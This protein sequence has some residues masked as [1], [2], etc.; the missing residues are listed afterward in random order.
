[1]VFLRGVYLWM[2]V[3]LT[4]LQSR[5]QSI[6]FNHLTIEN[7]LSHNSV[8]S[9]T[10]D[11]RGF[12]WYGTR[13]GLNRYDGARFRIYRMNLADTTTIPDN[14]IQYLFCD[15]KGTL[16]IGTTRGL[17]KYQPEKDAFERITLFPNM[18]PNVT[19]IYEDTKGRIW[20]ATNNGLVLDTGGTRKVFSTEH[21]L[22]GKLIRC[23]YE[24]KKGNIWVGT[25]T[26]L[27]RLRE[28]N[29]RFSFETFR[30]EDAGLPMNYITAV[31]EDRQGRIWIGTQSGGICLYNP[32]RHTFTPLL[33][34][35]PVSNYVRRILADKAGKMWI[36]TQEGLSI[37]DPVSLTGSNY[38]HNP[39]NKKSLSQNSIH[40]LYE[41][42]NGSIWIG[43]YF[44]GVNMIHSYGTAFMTWQ[45]NP[46]QTGLSNNVVS[47][48]WEDGHRNLWIGTE[49]GGLNYLNR[50][51]GKYTYYRH[52]PGNVGSIG[53]NLVKVVY[54]DKDHHIWVGTH[55]GGLNLLLPDG[56]FRHYYYDPQNPSMLTLEITALL[57]DAEN[58][59]WIGT[60][61][62]LHLMR[63][64]GAELLP[65]PDT[66]LNRIPHPQSIRCFF[67]DSR[68][69][70]LIGTVSGL[71]VYTNGQCTQVR[72]GYIN[73]V[74]EDSRGNIWIGI[75]H[76][77]MVRL[78]A[79][80]KSTGIYGEKEGLPNNNVIGILEDEQQQLW[81]STDNGL[82]KFDPGKKK[83][84]TYTTSDG[85]AGN[86]F[87]YNSFLKDSNGE[88]F[89]GGFNGITSFYPGKIVANTYTAPILFT[90]LHL[91]NDPVGIRQPDHLLK[92]DISFTNALRFHHNQEVFTLEFALLNYIRSN[93]N[94]YAYRLEGADRDWIETTIPAVTYTNLAAG[95]YTFWVKGANNDGIWSEPA[96]MDIT[97]LPPFWLT[98]W[99]WCIYALLVTAIIFMIA[100]Y[101][102][103]QALLKKE[104]DLHQVKLNFFTNV[105]HEIRTHLTLL[106]APVEKMTETLP[107]GDALQQPLSQVRNNAGR[108]LKLVSEL[109][110]FRKAETHHL[111]LH[112][113]EHDLI[114]FLQNIYESFRELSLSR[115]IHTAF[116]YD[117]EQA[118]LYFDPEQLEKVF[119]NLL[120]NAFKFT[121]DGGRIH[122]HVARGRGNY[123]IT[124]TDNGRGIAP[125]Y[126]P[127][128]FTN[129]FQVADHGLQNTGYGIG[130]ALSRNIVELH[131]GSLTVESE[132]PAGD[133]EGRTC[134]TVTLAEGRQHFADKP[135]E[136]PTQRTRAGQHEIPAAPTPEAAPFSIPAATPDAAPFNATAAAI[137][138][139]PASP[140][141]LQI[142]ED[143]PELR[144][145]IKD[146]FRRQYDV[147]EADNGAAGLALATE[148]IPDLII[149]DVMMPEM[150]GFQFCHAVKTDE[151]TSH[152]PVI[153]LTA[154]SSQADHV[155]GLETGA[156]LYLTKPFS[157]RVLELNVRNLLAAREKMREKF[158][159]QLTTTQP[160]LTTETLPNTVDTAFL[161]KVMQ[162]VDEHMDDPEFG[163]DMLA[164][165]VAM[166]QPVLYKKLK[167][168]TNMSVNDFV[169][170][171]RLKKAAELIRTRQHTVYEVAYMVGYNDRKYFS[172]E[173]KKQ[174]GKTPSEFA[175]EPE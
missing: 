3:L 139:I 79:E 141:R 60:N 23:I 156:D 128:L 166:S 157:T 50:Q 51:T 113:Q 55:A 90:G 130:L 62:G 150:D 6:V 107:P 19:Y 22:A 118:P 99:A 158:S 145:L 137:P 98:W 91:F 133:K 2:F 64:E 109:M 71:F 122:L 27:N 4:C 168:V 49:G 8:L 65:A 143:N 76:G 31:T 57:E 124:V 135:L 119:F 45:S 154:K 26:G 42:D 83:F 97:I 56:N 123:I 72:A 120:S 93:K 53:S 115:N 172:R 114:P 15:S 134:F 9:I 171:L 142:V 152:I 174:Y 127:K 52:Q 54:E 36:G 44:A 138:D 75:F 148:Q 163:V 37:I 63:R 116:T 110:D 11:K 175:G 25:T 73:S 70:I 104:E 74:M 35:A 29:G 40:S 146:T 78:N 24:D 126:L 159:R 39:G 155:S 153:L 61:N 18:L 149:S 101:F 77:G 14:H 84:L 112:V 121:P 102:F 147:L 86:D 34:P 169:K 117:A 162:L 105:S 43:T 12:M 81:I 21:G 67:Q 136:A 92:K 59:F 140:A 38:Q 94:R 80:L 144:Q 68:K 28:N 106:M 17:T 167:A 33:Q 30:K 7:G 132:P 111:K 66:V 47:S 1:M 100:R 69:R 131:H 13:Y 87:N 108:L 164:R 95:N 85:I 103:L 151:R 125:E 129:F 16:W 165:K 48:M 170:Q 82:V 58:R 41:D 46:P 173:F 160:P 89:F 96:K 88:F 20:I 161:E 5:G 10:Q 32:L